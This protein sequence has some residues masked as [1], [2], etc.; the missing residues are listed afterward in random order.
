MQPITIA[1]INRKGGVGKTST[2]HHMAGSLARA[3]SKVLLVDMDPQ[4]SLTQGFLGPELTEQ[5][6]KEKTISCLFDDRMEPEAED[7]IL[8][9]NFEGISLAPSAESLDAYNI[10][11]PQELGELQYSLRSFLKEVNSSYDV[12]LID[13]PPNLH[14]CSWNALVASDFVIIPVQAEDY[15]AQGITHVQKAIDLALKRENPR[16]KLLGYLVTMFTKRLG[17]HSIYDK[18]LRRLYG[19]QVFTAAVPL[20]KD[21]KESIALR[22]PVSFY[23]PKSKAGMAMDQIA[24]EMLTRVEMARNQPPEFLYLGN[25]VAVNN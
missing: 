22:K 10:P 21:F 11:T 19:N 8:E 23:K 24:E 17:I 15:G 13:C 20:M 4:A 3:G 18:Q 7:L 2:C 25:Q 5:L 16:L 6:P 9:T 14:L 1:V 12:I